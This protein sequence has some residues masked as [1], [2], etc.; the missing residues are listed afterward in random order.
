MHIT[1]ISGLKTQ[2]GDSWQGR[3]AKTILHLVLN[4]QIDE[5]MEFIETLPEVQNDF[6]Y[7]KLVLG[8][9]RFAIKQKNKVR[10]KVKRSPRDRTEYRRAG[11]LDV[12]FVV[13]YP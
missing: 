13:N 5:A 7:S 3:V 10:V 4:N 12:N 9:N 8:L 11:I 6:A 2:E 1:V